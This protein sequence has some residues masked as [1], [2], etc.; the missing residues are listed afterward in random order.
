M[1]QVFATSLPYLRS[2]LQS[3]KAAAS[4][5]DSSSSLQPLTALV[6]RLLG[7][8]APALS[9]CE[10]IAELGNDIASFV[11]SCREPTACEKYTEV[12]HIVPLLAIQPFFTS[13]AFLDLFSEGAALPGTLW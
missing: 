4:D 12:T 2:V 1:S 3:L 8:L 5:T 11:L 9:D 6:G 13:Y 10:H 7:Y